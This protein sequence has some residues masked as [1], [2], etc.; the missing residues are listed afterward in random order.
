MSTRVD[1]GTWTKEE[2][3]FGASARPW[4]FD[5]A[6]ARRVEILLEYE[7]DDPACAWMMLDDVR[8]E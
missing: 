5:V 1:T 4:S 3:T 2:F 7:G 6:G 8:L